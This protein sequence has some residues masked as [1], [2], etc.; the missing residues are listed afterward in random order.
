MGQ[1]VYAVCLKVCGSCQLCWNFKLSCHYL[2]SSP[3]QLFDWGFEAG[4]F[5]SEGKGRHQIKHDFFCRYQ[6]AYPLEMFATNNIWCLRKSRSQVGSAVFKAPPAQC[7]ALVVRN[8]FY[9]TRLSELWQLIKAKCIPPE[10]NV[11]CLHKVTQSQ[12]Q[13]LSQE[14]FRSTNPT[15]VWLTSSEQ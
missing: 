13:H 9:L 8:G 10:P 12:F 2:L 3:T 1:F 11:F 6:F 7:S 15:L 5:V 14:M 4:I